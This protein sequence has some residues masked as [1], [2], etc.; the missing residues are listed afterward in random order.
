MSLFFFYIFN[1][2]DYS[3]A[4]QFYESITQDCKINSVGNMCV[5]VGTIALIICIFNTRNYSTA[6]QFDDS[7][8]FNIHDYSTAL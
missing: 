2:H 8:I 7:F 3:T 4:L 1:T 5:V 6:L